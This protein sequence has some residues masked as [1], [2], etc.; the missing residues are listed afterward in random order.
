MRICDSRTGTTPSVALGG[1]AQYVIPNTLR[2][3]ATINNDF[4]TENLSPRLLDRAGI[5]TFPEIES[6]LQPADDMPPVQPIAWTS[7]QEIFGARST[8]LQD[9]QA[10]K[11]IYAYFDKLGLPVSMRTSNAITNYVSTGS[12]IFH[13]TGQKNATAIAIDFAV[14]QRL[15]PRING[16]GAD[17]CTRLKEL[18]KLL[19]KHQL[20]T[21][22]T[23]LD[24]LIQRGQE[25]MD[26]YHFF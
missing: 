25:N 15:L 4:T 9:H 8:Q 22:A 1:N 21:S 12:Q 24:R 7:L 14:M 5:V 19:L 23:H 10:L 13:S 18:H 3:L 20:S 17:F 2:F 6:T 11:D 26:W 16:N